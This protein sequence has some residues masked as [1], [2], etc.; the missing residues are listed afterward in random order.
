M[1]RRPITLLVI[2]LFSIPARASVEITFPLQ[3]FYRPGRYMPVRVRAAFENAGIGATFDIR[4]DNAMHTR[5]A[6]LAGR[7][8][9]VVPFLPGE[10]LRQLNW[11]FNPGTSGQKQ[12]ELI[13]QPFRALGPDQALVGFTTID[14]EFAHALFKDKSIVPIRLDSADPLPGTPA[15]WEMLDAV[16]LDAGAQIDISKIDSLLASGVI[17]AIRSSSQPNDRL[18]WRQIGNFWVAS[19]SL[20]GPTTAGENAAAFLPVLS[21]EAEWPASFRRRILLY[22]VVFSVLAMATSLLR[23]KWSALLVVS[24]SIVFT[25]GLWAWWRGKSAVLQRS[26]EILVLG[27]KLAQ[28]DTWTY[29]AAPREIAENEPWTEIT[30]PF[31]ESSAARLAMKPMLA[32]DENGLPRMFQ[33]HLGPG[34]KVGLLSRSLLPRPPAKP[35]NLANSP[36]ELLARQKY[37]SRGDTIAGQIHINTSDANKQR[38]DTIVIERDQRSSS[39][40]GQ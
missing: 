13:N 2:L 33:F 12:S 32:C 16:V 3:G 30:H 37:L 29:V 34:L 19:H 27:D 36:L 39:G 11:Q 9:G 38:W 26:G 7:A 23:T 5:L 15:A 4:A 20:A 31:F 35:Q 6:L 21:W 24:L 10:T 17:V 14:M 25:L 8:E 22:A 1:I 40:K 28:S 18:P